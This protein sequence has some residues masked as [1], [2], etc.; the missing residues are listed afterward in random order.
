[1]GQK[2]SSTLSLTVNV[3]DENHEM[4]TI[5]KWHETQQWTWAEVPDR[6]AEV[7]RI[8]LPSG[9]PEYLIVANKIADWNND[10]AK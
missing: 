1:M 4:F 3:Q 2:L 9:S 10:V 7:E 5:F 8:L 6:K